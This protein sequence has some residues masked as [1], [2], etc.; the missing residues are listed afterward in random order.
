[1]PS[2]CVFHPIRV[3]GGG[4][5]AAVKGLGHNLLMQFSTL[6]SSKM[7]I[8]ETDFFDILTIYNDQIFY[9]KH[10]SYRLYVSFTLFG[11]LEA[12]GEV[13]LK[14]LGHNLLMQ[15]STLCSSKTQICQTHFFD[16]LTIH[17]DQIPCFRP[18]LCVFHPIWVFGRGWGAPES[19]RNQRTD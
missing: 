14:G 18:S 13:V 15:F 8:S 1:M 16:I 4:I 3:F 17:N 10:V 12:W 6:S 2:L 5:Q 9:V 7:K 11:C 19:L